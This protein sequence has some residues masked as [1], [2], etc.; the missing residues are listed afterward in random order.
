MRFVA[1]T[2]AAV[3]AVAGSAGAGQTA[4]IFGQYAEIR[5]CDVYTGPCFAN[6]EV[7]LAG[8]EAILTW[9][10]DKGAWDGVA[11]DGLKVVAVVRAQ[12]TLG[13]P[14]S[15]PLPAKSVLFVDEKADAKQQKAL[16][17][18]AKDMGGELLQDVVKTEVAPIHTEITE[19]SKNECAKI[20]AGESVEV[21]ARCIQDGDK[22]CHNETAFYPPLV[23]GVRAMPHY[24]TNAAYSGDDLGIKFS[25]GGRSAY[26]GTFTR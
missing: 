22:I 5:T 14:D 21:S 26:V 19:C 10:V 11:L 20:Q 13:D 18:M 3:A 2:L 25:D 15:N 4:T 12:A 16:V 1:L 17:A 7:N 6:A 9:A 23:K 24:T 8:E